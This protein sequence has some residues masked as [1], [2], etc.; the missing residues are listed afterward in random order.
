MDEIQTEEPLNIEPDVSE[1]ATDEVEV[2]VTE[3]DDNVEVEEVPQEQK[4]AFDEAQQAK[5][6]SLISEKVAKTHE[7]RRLREEAEHRLAQLQ[8]QMPKPQEPT[9]PDLPDPDEFYGDPTGYNTK[10]QERDKAIQQRAEYDARNRMIQDQQQYQAR[11]SEHEAAL[12]QQVV[13]EG[14]TKTAESFGITG[15]QMQKD[16]ATVMQLGISNEISDYIVG[17]AAHGPLVSRF[18]ANNI[19]EAEKI[20]AMSPLQG[21][22]YIATEIK[23]KLTSARKATKAPAPANVVGGGGAPSRLDPNLEGV[24]FE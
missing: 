21:A 23:P 9:V 5:V 14:Y 17:D 18:L 12:K 6:N 10:L 13:I 2:E 22:V 24:T 11:Q 7:E 1:S 16:A 4:V 3:A 19:L 8:A 15:E 20:S